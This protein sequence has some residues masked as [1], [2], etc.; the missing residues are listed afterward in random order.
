MALLLIFL[1]NI[2][3]LRG[4]AGVQLREPHGNVLVDGRFADAEDGGGLPDGCAVLSNV[5]AEAHCAVI[6][7][8]RPRDG[9]VELL[10]LQC[11]SLPKA[12]PLCDPV[13]Y[14]ICR[15]LPENA[16][17]LPDSTRNF[18]AIIIVK[19]LTFVRFFGIIINGKCCF[20]KIAL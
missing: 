4:E 13:C 8:L 7:Q 9:S 18:H 10:F 3:H 19:R 1:D 14:T 12:D 17:P 6:E 15:G 5:G 2:P 11:A 20:S 16:Q